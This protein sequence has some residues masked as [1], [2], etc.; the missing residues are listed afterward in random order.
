VFTG[1]WNG[2]GNEGFETPLVDSKG[3]AGLCIL[4][5]KEKGACRR[6]VE[7]AGRLSGGGVWKEGLGDSA[8]NVKF[9]EQRRRE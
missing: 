1:W 2:E 3:E 6:R 4:I 5:S 7:T 9:D 8:I